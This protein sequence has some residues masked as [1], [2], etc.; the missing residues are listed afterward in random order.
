MNNR[1]LDDAVPSLARNELFYFIA[2]VCMILSIP[3]GSFFGARMIA[4][5][6]ALQAAQ[7]EQNINIKVLSAT[8]KDRLD[9]NVTQLTDHE[10]RLRT[11]EHSRQN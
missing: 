2:R 5:A 10:L 7:N 3:L 11:L 8:V 9:A 4:Q 1:D 6:D